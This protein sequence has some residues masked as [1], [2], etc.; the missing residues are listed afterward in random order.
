MALHSNEETTQEPLGWIELW[1]RDSKPT[2]QFLSGGHIR[3]H[4]QNTPSKT[5]WSVP[6]LALFCERTTWEECGVRDHW[7]LSLS[8]CPFLRGKDG[9]ICFWKACRLSMSIVILEWPAASAASRKKTARTRKDSKRT[10][11]A[12]KHGPLIQSYQDSNKDLIKRP[13]SY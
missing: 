13:G 4:F 3:E 1:L 11:N 2:N 12:L 6:W 9:H 5:A 7:I 10:F 8:I